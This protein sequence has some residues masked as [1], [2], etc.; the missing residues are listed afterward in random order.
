MRPSRRMIQLLLT[1]SFFK[2][3]F[4]PF[5]NHFNLTPAVY[6]STTT[7]LNHNIPA[8]R[9]P[10]DEHEFYKTIENEL[11]YYHQELADEKAIEISSQ[12]KQAWVRIRLLNQVNKL[13]CFDKALQLAHQTQNLLDEA[14]M[15][16]EDRDSIQNELDSI[17]P[18]LTTPQPTA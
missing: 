5:H 9:Y 12:F 17:N 1:H 14:P 7:Q 10:Q 18:M 11:A 15:Q 13:E 6:S 3:Q 16:P 2:K 4:S 8:N